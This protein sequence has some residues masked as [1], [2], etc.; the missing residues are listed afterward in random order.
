MRDTLT[1]TPHAASM[2]LSQ[3]YLA[4]SVCNRREPADAGVGLCPDC[5]APYLAHLDGPVPDRGKIGSRW[6]MWRYGPALPV[7][8]PDDVLT[9]GEG[10]TPLI[11]SS[12]LAEW[13]GVRRLWIKD[14]G[15]NP[16]ASFKS[17]GLAMSVMRA[18][19]RGVSG[20]VVPTAGN[21]GAALAAY[22]AAA[23]VPV[24]VYAP[25]TTPAPIL[26]TVRAMGVELVTVPGHIGDAGRLAMAFAAASGYFNV[27]TLREPFR[28]EGNKTLGLELVEQLGW[29]F[30]DAVV[31]PTGGGEG[32]IGIW[33]AFCEMKEWG[34]VSAD[35][36]L[37]SLAVA[38]ATGCAP[39]VRA[40]I[41][42]LD[43][44]TPW[45]NPVTHAAGLRV[46]SPLG[47]R[48]VLR[49]LR[50]SR[51]SAAAIDEESI[52]AATLL[53]ASGTG[54]DAAPEGGCA[55][56]AARELVRAKR[57]SAAGE[58]VVFN[59]GSGASYRT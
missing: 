13:V 59:T 55:L 6:D 20:L 31:Y 37:P 30:P 7:D 23:G 41:D 38:Q 57:I 12:S 22:G 35:A 27:A 14:E 46:P 18:K 45:E 53:L 56:A 19:A 26:G 10:C 15:V 39:L 34:W 29:R 1:T 32:V 21:A 43:R 3:W 44:A 47:D 8:S 42:G 16:T 51:G 17:R 48:L 33:K 40:W 11:E 4:C 36:Q 52:S 49:A 28:V 9:L 50:E 58:V 2:T 25:D 54:I 24:R 5:Q